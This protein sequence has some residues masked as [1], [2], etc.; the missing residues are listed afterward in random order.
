[1]NWYTLRVRYALR[2]I[3][4]LGGISVHR[5]M[6][7]NGY[8]WA[9]GMKQIPIGGQRYLFH[10]NWKYV[11]LGDLVAQKGTVKVSSFGFAEKLVHFFPIPQ[12]FSVAPSKMNKYTSWKWQ[13][14]HWQILGARKWFH[15]AQ[16]SVLHVFSI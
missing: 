5:Y 9:E 6:A 16:A 13:P 8:D 3:D 4:A 2:I 1:M 10:I 11:L 14:S 12:A 7:L 15:L